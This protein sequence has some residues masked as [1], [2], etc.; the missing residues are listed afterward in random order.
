[1]TSQPWWFIRETHLEEKSA[2]NWVKKEGPAGIRIQAGE[3]REKYS[4][5][6][7]LP[8]A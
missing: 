5:R 1:M 8:Y 2:R 4:P 7:R 6:Q 3:T